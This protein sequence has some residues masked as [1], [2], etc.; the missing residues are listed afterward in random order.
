MLCETRAPSVR[1]SFPGL[2]TLSGLKNMFV[3]CVNPL[4][5]KETHMMCTMSLD[6][7]MFPNRTCC[8]FMA[9]KSSCTHMFTKSHISSLKS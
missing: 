4:D 2:I 5:D 1:Q 3:P 9:F 8:F 7:K 6:M